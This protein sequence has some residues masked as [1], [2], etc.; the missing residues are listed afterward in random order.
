MKLS[1]WIKK[2]KIT[3]NQLAKKLGVTQQAISR[4]VSGEPPIR[5]IAFKIIDIANGD[6]SLKDLWPKN[7]Q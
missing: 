7:G 6:I 1:T 2:Q 3:Q 5:K 4:Y